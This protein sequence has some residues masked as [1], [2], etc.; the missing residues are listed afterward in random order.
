M[1]GEKISK[2]DRKSQRESVLIAGQKSLKASAQTVMISNRNHT[3][4]F[5]AIKAKNG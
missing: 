1:W 4:S 3:H 5:L 2:S